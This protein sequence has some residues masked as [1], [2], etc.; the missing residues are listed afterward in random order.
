MNPNHRRSRR[1]KFLIGN[2]PSPPTKFSQGSISFL[3]RLAFREKWKTDIKFGSV[4]VLFCISSSTILG[5]SFSFS[6]FCCRS[7]FLDC[8]II[9]PEQF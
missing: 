1:R 2:V 6:R 4:Y 9:N 7:G 8:L 3:D 5:K